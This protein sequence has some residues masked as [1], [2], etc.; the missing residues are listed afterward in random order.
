MLLTIPTP[1]RA[2]DVVMHDGAIVRV[3]QHGRRE[4]PRL[5]LSHGNGLAI[6]GYMPFWGP[7]ADRYDLV[8]FDMRNHG[9]NPPHGPI[10]HDW[11]TFVRDIERVWR[12]IRDRL[13][14]RPAVGVFHSLSAIAAT[15]HALEGG[16]RWPALV[17]FDPPF[18]PRAGHPLQPVEHQHMVD[19]ARRAR[20]RRGR[21]HD[22]DLLASQFRTRRAFRR[23]VP[24]A[25][26]LMAHATMRR[27]NNGSDWVLACP[28]ELE[29]RIFENNADPEIWPRLARLD[30]PI[31]LICADPT[32]EEVQQPAL[33]CQAMAEE[34]ALEYESIPDTSHF[35]QIEKPVDCIR[36]LEDFLAKRGHRA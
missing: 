11:A 23:W 8:M 28:P 27:D 13:G 36:S 10:G 4:G 18:Y 1:H 34:L 19:M 9:Q 35:L 14:A 22:P 7:L 29:A 16:D 15:L 25:A 32:L 33:V 3:R 5:I 21:F 6:D 12:A 30:L 20:Q 26:A 31:K 24:G 17:L 2:F